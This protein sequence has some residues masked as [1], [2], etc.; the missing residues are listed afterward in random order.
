MFVCVN[1]GV[2]AWPAR[3]RHPHLGRVR[4]RSPSQL[5]ESQA[6]HLGTGDRSEAT[7]RRTSQRERQT[8]SV[9]EPCFPFAWILGESC[10]LGPCGC[11]GTATEGGAPAGYPEAPARRGGA[12]GA[13]REEWAFLS[14][15][16]HRLLF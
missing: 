13:P 6:A 14:P 4:W 3:G 15:G 11:Q 8:L 9:E 16:P 7:E 1:T 10:S 12:G 5:H 2:G